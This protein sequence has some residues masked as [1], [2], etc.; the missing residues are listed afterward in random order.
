MKLKQ[1]S[2]TEVIEKAAVLYERYE[3]HQSALPS[4]SCRFGLVGLHL[5]KYYLALKPN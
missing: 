3:W 5:A 1:Q 4:W 2:H